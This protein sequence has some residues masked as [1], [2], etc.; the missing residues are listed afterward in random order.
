MS[1]TARQARV[2]RSS[3]NFCF[4]SARA[5]KHV[6]A[7]SKIATGEL[8]DGTRCDAALLFVAVRSDVQTFQ[9]NTAACPAFGRHLNAAIQAGVRVHAR[10]LR[11]RVAEDLSTA[12]AFDDGPLPLRLE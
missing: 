10:R 2:Y 8:K 7:L 12:G 1:A 3:P 11:W 9:P 4:V 5:L 6:D